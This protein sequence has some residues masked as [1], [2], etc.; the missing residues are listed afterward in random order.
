MADVGHGGG[1]GHTVQLGQPALGVGVGGIEGHL[2]FPGGLVDHGVFLDV[3]VIPAR[4]LIQ[5]AE[6]AAAR[7]DSGDILLTV[8]QADV[9][10]GGHDRLA[11]GSV[12][13]YQGGAEGG[14]G[15]IV[16]I[17][18]LQ[19]DAG[20]VLEIHIVFRRVDEQGGVAALD[21]HVF[22]P[23]EGENGL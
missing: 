22:R 1:E 5:H 20:G 13:A 12:Q 4:R 21:G 2:E 3:H 16:E 9:P 18:A 8:F 6:P 10:V 23:A 17:E 14:L 19:G 11:S 15:F 7:V